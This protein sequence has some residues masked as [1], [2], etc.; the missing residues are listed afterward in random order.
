[1][2]K[3]D[4][5][6]GV[7]N[8]CV[9]KWSTNAISGQNKV[10][11]KGVDALTVAKSNLLVGD[12][13]GNISFLDF[14]LKKLKSVNQFESINRI[15][16]AIDISEDGNTLILGTYGADIIE[17]DLG[18]NSST[19][20]ISGHYTPDRGKTVTNEVWGLAVFPDGEHYVT[21]S[22]DGTLRVWNVEE[23]KMTKLIDLK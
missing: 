15:I 17:F 9:Y 18:S 6:T 10:C 19:T 22:D 1:M 8:G 13:D 14:Q 4:I 11:P 21:T 7:A 16:R 20:L 5:F 3:Q 2:N 12:K 23:R